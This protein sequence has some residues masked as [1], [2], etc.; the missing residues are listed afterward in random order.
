[1]AR[2]L[3]KHIDMTLDPESISEALQTVKDLQGWLSD[4]LAELARY[5]T[6]ER[7]KEIAQ[8]HIARLGAVDS[9]TLHNS[10]EGKYDTKAHS[11]TLSANVEYAV[12]VEFGTGIVGATGKSHPAAKEKGWDYDRN[13]H[14]NA[15][16]YYPSENGKWIPKE[17]KYK[18]QRMAWT[19]GTAARPFLYSTMLDLEEIAKREGG[20]FIAQYIP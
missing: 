2:I 11:G 20:Q 15:G 17:G 14:G 9:G 12:Y 16:W 3:L 8:M 7:G 10:I 6:E 18:G 1:M 13:H 5:L 19:K 4:A